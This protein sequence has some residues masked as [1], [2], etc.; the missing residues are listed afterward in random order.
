MP[1]F[2]IASR[3]CLVPGAWDLTTNTLDHSEAALLAAIAEQLVPLDEVPG[4]SQSRVVRFIDQQLEGALAR[5]RPAYHQGLKAFECTCKTETGCDFIEL[6]PLQRAAYLSRIER[7]HKLTAFC[8]ILREH[9]RQSL[10]GGPLQF[11]KPLVQR[12]HAV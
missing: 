10:S 3:R 12:Q 8:E 11:Q 6:S 5:L 9:A 1:L 4:S 2:R 7:G